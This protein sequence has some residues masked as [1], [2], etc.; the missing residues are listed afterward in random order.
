MEDSEGESSASFRRF[1]LGEDISSARLR[2]EG[3]PEGD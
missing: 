1:E 3:D 2:P